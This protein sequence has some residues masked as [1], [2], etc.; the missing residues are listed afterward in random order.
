MVMLFA[1]RVSLVVRVIF[2][3]FLLDLFCMHWLF[4]LSNDVF[5]LDR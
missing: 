4:W 3:F 5:F 2:F 1:K